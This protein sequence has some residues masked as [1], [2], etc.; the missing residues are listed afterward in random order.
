MGRARIAD[1]RRSPC[2]SAQPWEAHLESCVQS[3]ALQDR[4][5][6]ERGQQRLQRSLRAWSISDRER[7]REM[8]LSGLDRS[9]QPWAQALLWGPSNGTRAMGRD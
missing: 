1:R 7:L 3:W 5:L 4:E 9:P 2:S 8:G 6:L